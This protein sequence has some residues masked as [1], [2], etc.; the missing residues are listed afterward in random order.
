MASDD[1]DRIVN[2]EFTNDRPEWLPEK[3]GR[4]CDRCGADIYPG[5]SDLASDDGAVLC[6][7]CYSAVTP[8]RTTSDQAKQGFAV[9]TKLLAKLHLDIAGLADAGRLDHDA[10]MQL[11]D[12]L[13][14]VWDQ[15]YFGTLCAV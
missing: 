8:P 13:H 11:Q 7:P 1:D 4:R 6:A 15:L 9:G 5:E 10:A 12:D 14:K 2:N 3:A